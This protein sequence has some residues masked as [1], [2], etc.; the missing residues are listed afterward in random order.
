I[1]AIVGAGIAGAAFYLGGEVSKGITGAG[2]KICA[3]PTAAVR[4]SANTSVTGCGGMI[5]PRP[6][7][8][9]GGLS[10]GSGTS[11]RLRWRYSS[12]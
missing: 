5:P 9:F 3:A 7:S 12:V 2:N 1:L 6:F 11:S 10:W 8:D 4:R